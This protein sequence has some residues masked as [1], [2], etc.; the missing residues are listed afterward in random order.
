MLRP[1]ERPASQAVLRPVEVRPGLLR[2]L[3]LTA[4]RIVLFVCVENAARSLMAES[5]FNADPAPGWRATSAGTRPGPAPNPRTA[6][7]LSEVGLGLPD[8][9]PQLLTPSLM[10]RATL[11]ITMGCLDDRSCPAHLKALDPRDWNLPDPATMDDSGFREV[12]DRIVTLVRGSGR[13]CPA[14]IGM[15]TAT[16]GPLP[17]E[18]PAP[19]PSHRRALRDRPPRWDRDRKHRPGVRLGGFPQY[20]LAIAWFLAVLVPILLFVEVSGAHLNPVVTLGLALSRRIDWREVPPYVVSQLAGAF[21]GSAIVLVSLGDLAHLGAT[22]PAQADALRAFVLEF[23]FTAALVAS[24]FVLADRGVGRWRWRL[25][26]PPAVVGVSTYLIGPWTG[27]SLNP[28]RTIA[29]AVLSAT[30]SE[31]WVYLI[32]V[33]LA[34]CVVALAWRPRSVD[35]LDRGPGRVET[36]A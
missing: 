20:V 18:G 16:F 6:P 9:P 33:P 27:S 3:L 17:G 21:L 13:N 11:P 2:R 35:R 31:I 5:V 30:Y 32:A 12:R 34:A 28:A 29:P 4:P 22:V 24:V 7:M 15:L 1:V 14:R 19:A 36:S 23:A 8:H 10:D 25:A 26:L